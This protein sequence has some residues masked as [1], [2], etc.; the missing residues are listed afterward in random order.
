MNSILLLMQKSINFRFPFSR[1]YIQN[2]ITLL[3]C[4]LG[5]AEKQDS[6]QSQSICH[7]TNT[8]V[9]LSKES[10]ENKTLFYLLQV[11][12]SLLE[13]SMGEDLR[14]EALLTKS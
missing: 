14:D 9:G 13:A 3:I 2:C 6:P 4:L 8:H 1:L 5:K 7:V 11:K 10:K 12:G